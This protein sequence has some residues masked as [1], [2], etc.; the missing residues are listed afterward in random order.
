MAS[1]CDTLKE[2]SSNVRCSPVPVGRGQQLFV[3]QQQHEGSL[4]RMP[5]LT[6]HPIERGDLR[7]CLLD[8]ASVSNPDP[9]SI[10]SVCN[11][12]Y[13]AHNCFDLF[14]SDELNK[15]CSQVV[16]GE[17]TGQM[18][19]ESHVFDSMN[20]YSSTCAYGVDMHTFRKLLSGQS[21]SFVDFLKAEGLLTRL[22]VTLTDH[23]RRLVCFSAWLVLIGRFCGHIPFMRMRKCSV[24]MIG[25]SPHESCCPGPS[26]SG[27]MTGF[28]RISKTLIKGI[29]IWAFAVSEMS[30]I[31]E[32]YFGC[33][34]YDVDWCAMHG[35]ACI[36]NIENVP[37]NIFYDGSGSS[38]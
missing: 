29:S 4:L 1:G 38:P 28:D 13:W 27:Y 33:W 35:L 26:G 8:E 16:G 20:D 25:Y 5:S 37:T 6:R 31:R 15:W 22:V 17:P 24:A 12:P 9:S 36:D 14:S 11:D 30:R 10:D 19:G 23:R 2:V 3:E 18:Y 32:E 21:L 7:Y 34:S